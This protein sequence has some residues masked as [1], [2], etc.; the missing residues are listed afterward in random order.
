MKQRY[1]VR[2]EDQCQLKIYLLKEEAEVF[3]ALIKGRGQTV[4]DHLESYI[5]LVIGSDNK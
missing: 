1:E 5:R 2:R 3:K 4:Q